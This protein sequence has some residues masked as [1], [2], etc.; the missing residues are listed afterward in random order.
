MIDVIGD[1]AA[2]TLGYG[3]DP[4]I[5][6]SLGD[7]GVRMMLLKFGLRNDVLPFFASTPEVTGIFESICSMNSSHCQIFGDAGHV[8]HMYDTLNKKK[9]Q[10]HIG[11]LYACTFAIVIGR[12]LVS[13]HF[14]T[15]VTCACSEAG[16]TS[17]HF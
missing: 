8:M 2:S 9:V 17:C 5:R 6:F 14:G 4:R 15:S 1:T 3:Y 10:I 13:A 12:C 7:S 11:P 16:R